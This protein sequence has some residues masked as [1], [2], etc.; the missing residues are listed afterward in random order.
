MV[1]YLKGSLL[2]CQHYISGRI[3]KHEGD[4]RIASTGGLPLIIP[5]IVRIS[6]KSG[7]LA[8]IKTVLGI[9]SLF[10]VLPCK[11]KEKLSTITDQ[12]T[13]LIPILPHVEVDSIFRELFYPLKG[14]LPK[15]RK[16]LLNLKTAGPNFKPAILGAPY[17]AY[18]HA[19]NKV[20]LYPIQVLS[21]YF[22]SEIHTQLRDEIHVVKD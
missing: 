20:L 21:T 12:Y 4:I 13:G 3:I 8:V 17:D 18:S 2:L 6:M 11:G 15:G 19:L 1:S 5:G 22:E 9:L 14:S 10:R 16:F 7:D